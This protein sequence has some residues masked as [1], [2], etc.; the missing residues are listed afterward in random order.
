MSPR[1]PK[2]RPSAL[3]ENAADSAELKRPTQTALSAEL[4]ILGTALTAAY[5]RRVTKSEDGNTQTVLT[6]YLLLPTA[7]PSSGMS[8]AD[9]INDVR[10]LVVQLGGQPADDLGDKVTKSLESTGAAGSTALE[11]IRVQLQQA[12][13]Y[14]SSEEVFQKSGETFPATPTTT[15][16]DF[17]YA[18][19]LRISSTF[20]PSSIISLAS[21]SISIWNTKRQDVLKRMQLGSIAQLLGSISSDK[22]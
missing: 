12:F 20:K 6:E 21:I 7:T 22:S 4:S 15:K 13:L 14:H 10:N 19:T 5:E 11:Q 18:F 2:Q 17:E 9:L 1:R 16:K 3:S 8:I